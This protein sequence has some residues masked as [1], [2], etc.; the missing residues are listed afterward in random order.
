MRNEI[1]KLIKNEE[2]KRDKVRYNELL[3]MYADE[4]SV[5]QVYHYQL[6]YTP[7]KLENLIYD[8]KK[9]FYISDKDVAVFKEDDEDSPMDEKKSGVQG[10]V[11]GNGNE[12]KKTLDKF[13]ELSAS[14]KKAEETLAALKLDENPDVM[15]GLKLREEYPFLND[16]NT[17]T[18]IK[19]LV[20]DKITA[21]KKYAAVHADILEAENDN[22]AEEKLYELAKSA[23]AHFEVNQIIKK[24]LDFY[25]DSEGRILGKHPSLE[26]LRLKQDV[27]DMQEVDLVKARVNSQ[28]NIHRYDKEKKPEHVARWK[29]K[30][31]LIEKRLKEEFNHPLN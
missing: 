7:Q 6:G 12:I 18:E 21:Y 9:H 31:E 1:I 5:R 16:E 28:K 4:T 23:L 10:I 15:E 25:R 26:Y 3:R 17:S 13:K 22:D 11:F 2:S 20:T 19:A 14:Q 27:Y 24:E 8:I 29:Y 30:L